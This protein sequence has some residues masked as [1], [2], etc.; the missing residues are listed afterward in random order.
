MNKCK[1][2]SITNEKGGVGKTTTAL[3]LGV[4]IAKRGFR[5]LVIDLDSQANMTDS[6]GYR[7]HDNFKHTIG[8]AMLN[9]IDDKTIDYSDY[10]LHHDEGIDLIPSN[11][12]LSTVDMALMSAY[13]REKTL[14][15]IINPLRDK[16]DYILMD[17]PPSL[18][19][20]TINALAA[21]DSV[22]IPVQA[23]YLSAK[24]MTQLIQT[25]QRVK[26]FINPKLT[27]DG[28]LM[29]LVDN[30]TNLA[31]STYKAISEGYGDQIKIFRNQIP[32]GIKAAEAASKGES[33]Y[34]YD[35]KCKVALAYDGLVKEVLSLERIRNRDTPER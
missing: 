6:L 9:V 26:K 4:G 35:P 29:T 21:A 11:I 5:V 1:T 28:I 15:C 24:G 17:C 3:N 22:I 23:Q 33:L 19:L 12:E 32:M 2:I 31:R 10:I 14:D 13:C 27:V 16:Y 34:S 8:S 25:V 30:R 18:S 7:N 20:I